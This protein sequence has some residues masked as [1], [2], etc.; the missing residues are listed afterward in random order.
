MRARPPSSGV[1]DIAALVDNV[2]AGGVSVS[3]DDDGGWQTASAAAQLCAYRL[4]QEGLTNAVRHAPTAPVMISLTA[5]AGV[6]RVAVLT[7]G[8][9]T[10]ALS[11][12]PGRGL[13]GLATRVA[14]VSGEFWSGPTPQGWLLEARVPLHP[15]RSEG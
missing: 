13:T 14:A 7:A 15:A 12:G 2:R 10:S 5:A 6:G 3:L 8:P 1:A 11:D 9:E 4:V